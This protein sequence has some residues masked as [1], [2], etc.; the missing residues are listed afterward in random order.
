MNALICL[1]QLKLFTYTFFVV[2]VNLIFD[3]VVT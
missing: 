1:K 2:I 3:G